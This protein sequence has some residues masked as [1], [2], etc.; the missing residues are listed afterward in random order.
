MTGYPVPSAS[1]V[2]TAPHGVTLPAP[3][4]PSYPTPSRPNRVVQ[5][6]NLPKGAPPAPPIPLV[7][8]TLPK[9]VSRPQR[10]NLPPVMKLNLVSL[11]PPP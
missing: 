6:A 8:L 1:L 7:G 4:P 9:Q 3:A 2:S 5:P 11:K 10:E